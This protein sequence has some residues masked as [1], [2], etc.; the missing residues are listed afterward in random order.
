MHLSMHMLVGTSAGSTERLG[1]SEAIPAKPAQTH[2]TGGS[3]DPIMQAKPIASLIPD[4]L[5]ASGL[6]YVH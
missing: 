6:G 2:S 3:F 5:L 1:R 4:H